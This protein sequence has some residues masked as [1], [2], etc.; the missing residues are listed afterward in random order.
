[1]AE[2]RSVPQKCTSI[3]ASFTRVVRKG[4]T[5]V[6]LLVVIGIIALLVAILLPALN[7]A[8]EQGN[9]AACMSNLKQIGNA[10]LLYSNENKGFMLR[11]A[12]NGNGQMPDDLLIWR[13]TPTPPLKSIDD[14][15]I[16]TLLNLKGDRLQQLFR[17]PSDQALDRA[18]EAGFSQAY[19][20][21]YTMSDYW[22]KTPDAPT[23]STPNGWLKVHRPKLTQVVNSSQKVCI[24]EEKNPNDGRCV[25]A[26]ILDR[27][28]VLADRHAH[29]GNLLFH[30][31]H[32]ERKTAKELQDGADRYFNIYIP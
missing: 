8:R 31:W 20:Y 30:D 23:P 1:M 17:C 24:V 25:H 28:D 32:V 2:D 4:F 27:D 15:L 13:Q 19:R 21:S 12:S 22:D 29:Q 10:M 16:A 3:G 14:S 5:L 7:K 6:E 26:N 9:W 18:P 11:P